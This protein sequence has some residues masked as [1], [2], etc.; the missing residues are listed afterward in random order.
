MLVPR[1]HRCAAAMKRRPPQGSQVVPAIG[2]D[3]LARRSLSRPT[4]VLPRDT[5]S[6]RHHPCAGSVLSMQHF[7]SQ[8]KTL[9]RTDRWYS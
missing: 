2:N 1:A 9:Y 6:S 4:R 3:V 5:S 7:L 8:A